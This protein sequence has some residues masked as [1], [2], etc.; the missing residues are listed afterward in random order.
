[1]SEKQF[2]EGIWFNKPHDKAPDFVKMNVKIE[3]RKLEQWIAT[4]NDEIYISVKESKGGKWYAEIDT[5]KPKPK[6][7][8]EPEAPAGDDLPF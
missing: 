7:E 1:M 3:S 5:Y 4:Q 2:A 8:L 6:A